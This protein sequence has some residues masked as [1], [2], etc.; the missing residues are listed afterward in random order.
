MQI[1]V[2]I[3]FSKRNLP[4]SECSSDKSLQSQSWSHSQLFGI[5]SPESHLVNGKELGI[6][7]D[8]YPLLRQLLPELCLSASI[9]QAIVFV[10]M[11]FAVVFTV[12]DKP[13]INASS[14]AAPEV[15]RS[16]SLFA[17]TRPRLTLMLIGFVFAIELVIANL[18][19]LNTNNLYYYWSHFKSRKISQIKS[20]S[21]KYT[22]HRCKR[23]TQ[24]DNASPFDSHPRLLPLDSLSFRCILKYLRCKCWTK[25]T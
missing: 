5:H 2:G 23:N 3:E 9:G 16:T 13:F 22:L 12:A 1:D 25:S 15:V 18:L 8:D 19:F 21:P 10:C 14:I 24:Q 6:I 11:I 4:H 17:A 20:G 7:K